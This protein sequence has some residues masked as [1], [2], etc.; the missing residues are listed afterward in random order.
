[1]PE[2]QKLG[3]YELRQVLGRGAM[4]VVYEGF[5]TSLGRR[6]AVKTILKSAAIDA[7][8]ARAYEARFVQ[9]AKAVARLNHP[10]IVQVYDFGEENEVAYLVMEYIEGR[11]LRGFFVDGETFTVGE[12]IRIMG[13]LLDALEFAHEAG[14]IHRDIKPANVMLDAQRRLKLADFGVAR[15]QEGAEHSQTGTMVGTPAFMSPEQI[16]GGRIDRRT[17][18]FSAGTILYQLLT[19]EQPFKGG[20]P[21]TVAKKIM[22]DDPPPPS[23]VVRSLSPALDAIVDKA[24]AKNPRERF[25]S[26]RD[27]AASL[28]ASMSSVAPAE[29]T[30]PQAPKASPGARTGAAE[31]EFWRSIQYSTDPHEFEF[32]LANFP[33]GVYAQLAR[34]K[35]AKLNEPLEVARKAA[36]ETARLEAEERAA[37]HALEE[38][39][40]EAERKAELQAEKRRAQEKARADAALAAQREAEDKARREAEDRARREAE[41]RE[42][43]R[44]TTEALERRQAEARAKRRAEEAASEQARLEAAEAARREAEVHVRRAAEAR[45]RARV[46][47]ETRARTDAQEKARRDADARERARVEAEARARKEAEDK[48]RRDA[49]LAVTFA[50]GLAAP[51]QTP[52]ARKKLPLLPAIM[53]VA[54]LAAA[55]GAYMLSGNSPDPVPVA[56]APLVEKAAPPKVEAPPPA[57]PKTEPAGV[58]RATEERIRKET[59]ERVRREYSDKAAVEKVIADKAAAKGAAE[60]LAPEKAAAAKATAEKVA[61]EKAAAE[62]VAADRAAMEKAAAEKIAAE[63]AAADKEA[64]AKAAADKVAAEKETM[65]KLAGEK[66]AADQA[67]LREEAAAKPAY[68]P[69]RTGTRSWDYQ[70]FNNG[71]PTIRGYVTLDQKNGKA[72]LLFAA[73]VNFDVC[74]SGN[75]DATVVETEA[76]T[77]ITALRDM[78]GCQQFRLLI[79]NNGTGGRRETWNGTKWVGERFDRGLTPRK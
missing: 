77:T 3:R 62:K 12:A 67:A 26:A 13:E 76:T 4:G 47:A 49:D 30:I 73:G 61:V 65:E 19:G 11:E 27:F 28:R 55:G 50:N 58:D 59:E 48:A 17:D 8:T 40:R 36:E 41:A 18:L 15:I 42:K 7:E 29:P 35:F 54:V 69:P 23:S 45:E 25:A 31:I 6:V 33:N 70:V 51:P 60:K 5:D 56:T 21:W 63:R 9:E 79:R 22:E 43:E 71:Q 64:T 66:W 37:R 39:Q 57:P 14:V 20:G 2:I 24:L 44:L 46:E 75:L 74:Q 78:R 38:A 10:N 32:Y 72:V 52:D 53:A 16:S 1:M 34:H 68:V